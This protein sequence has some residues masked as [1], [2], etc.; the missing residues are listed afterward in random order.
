M[1]ENKI[2]LEMLSQC[3][4]V[5][6]MCSQKD[7]VDLQK[8]KLM[9]FILSVQ[10]NAVHFISSSIDGQIEETSLLRC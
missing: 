4:S 1:T 5:V 2:Y 3:G 7:H 6:L 8:R 10:E 9:M